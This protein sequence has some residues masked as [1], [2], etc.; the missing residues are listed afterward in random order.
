VYLSRFNKKKIPIA[1][2]MAKDR[3]G[4]TVPAEMKDIVIAMGT[5]NA[6][7]MPPRLL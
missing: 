7:E 6:I 2:S 5:A 1:M 4:A 3:N